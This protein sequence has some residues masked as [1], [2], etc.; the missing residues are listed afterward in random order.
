ML[1]STR[2]DDA[3]SRLKG[4]FLEVPGT[5]LSV[6][7]ACEVARLDEETCHLLLLALVEARFLSRSRAGDFLLRT[8]Q[9]LAAEP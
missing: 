8:G 9:C 1:T 5:E 6:E 3:L 4:L 7:Q 2:I